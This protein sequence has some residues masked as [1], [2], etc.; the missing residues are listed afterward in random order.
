MPRDFEE[1]EHTADRAY[2]AYGRDLRE[3]FVNAARALLAMEGAAEDAGPATAR[4]VRVQGI[5]RET[6]L[7]NWLNELLYLEERH[8]ERYTDVRI[9]ELSEQHLAASLAGVAVTTPKRKIKAVTFHDLKV[10]RGDEGWQATIVVD[11]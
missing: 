10:T 5:D 7:V 11:V 3:L 1:I 4:D 2:R 8:G 9:A 6:L